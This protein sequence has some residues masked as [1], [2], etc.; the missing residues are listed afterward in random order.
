MLET[1][2]GSSNYMFPI[3]FNVSSSISVVFRGA[4]KTSLK[5]NQSAYVVVAE[6]EGISV[7]RFQCFVSYSLHSETKKV[8]Y[9]IIK[10]F[11]H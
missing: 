10:L 2:F 6:N 4:V 5:R 7:S 1:T 3:Y 8:A 9:L 11:E